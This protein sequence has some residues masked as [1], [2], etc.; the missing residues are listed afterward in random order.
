M[1]YSRFNYVAQPEDGIDPDDL[2]PKIGPYDIFSIKWGYTPIPAAKTPDEE[3]P[4]LNEWCKVQ[5]TT[6]WL[7]FNTAGSL[8]TDP[9]EESEAVGDIDAVKA[10]GLGIKN[11]HRVMDILP[12]AVL[13][14]GEDYRQLDHMY[15]AVWS[16][17]SYELGHVANIVGGFDSQ[18]KVGLAPG[19]RF[20][21]VAKARQQ[22]AVSFLN[23]NIFQTPAWLFPTE[24]LGK[25][26]PTSGQAR[27]ASLQQSVLNNL[28]RQN[29]VGRLQE[30][31]AILG[32]KAYT[33][34]QLLTDLRGG[35]FTELQAEAVKIDPY[36][37]NL[38]R[39]FIDLLGSRLAPAQ[40]AASS[41]AAPAASAGLRSD[42]SR[43][44]IRAE[45]KTLQ[46]MFTDKAIKAADTV[47]KTHLE[48]LRDQI[49]MILEP[50]K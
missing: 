44:A 28:L 13:K 11:L 19:V 25:L 12:R 31:E 36:R 42:D 39:A 46:M 2:I 16:Q 3:K 41:A 10:T 21:P 38:Q 37:R 33:I 27:L 40:A 14:P 47:T 23:E 26:E 35:V 49:T 48:D 9:G 32:D 4:V 43:G 29:R 45:L 8:G 30:H 7:R 22:E 24:I 17:L 5:E 1:D 18:P 20:T 6:P 34:A 50:K 15:A